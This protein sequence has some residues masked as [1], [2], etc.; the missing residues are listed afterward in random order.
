MNS[1]SIQFVC[2]ECGKEFAS[3]GNLGRHYQTNPTSR[4]SERQATANA[5]STTE[6]FL[7]NLK[8]YRVGRVREISKQLSIK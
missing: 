5:V 4:A 6:S 1:S 7:N 3:K 8:H 2:K